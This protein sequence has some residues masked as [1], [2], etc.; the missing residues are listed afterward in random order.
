LLRGT[1]WGVIAVVVAILLP[2][3]C[4]VARTVRGRRT[5]DL[6][7]EELRL[8]KALDE[9]AKGNPKAYLSVEFAAYRA[10]V[11]K[12]DVKVR[13]L[14]EIGYLKESNIENGYVGHRP[15][16]ITVGGMLRAKKRR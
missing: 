14:K 11:E 4:L 13:R 12:C 1:P 6:T 10:E 15:V 7:R 16:W 8:L 3:L 9:Q 5:S 2:A